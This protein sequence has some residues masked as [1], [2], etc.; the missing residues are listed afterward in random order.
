[1][2]VV[3]RQWVSVKRYRGT[4]AF[5]FLIPILLCLSPLVTG[6]VKEQWFYVVGG[7]AL[8]TMVLAPSALR[9]DFRRDLRRMLLLRSLPVKPLSMVLGQVGLPITITWIFQWFTICVAAIVTRPGGD[10]ILLWTALLNA[11]AVFIFAAENA[12]FLA[13]PHHERSEGVA[14]MVRAKLTFLA[15]GTLILL[16]LGLLVAWATLCRRLLSP[17]YAETAFVSGSLVASWAV[18][19]VAVA[20]ATICWRR[21]DAGID[22]PPQ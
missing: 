10:Q 20:A 14:M 9:L 6:Q 11:L 5:S 2:A 15:K 7:I 8:C 13:Y 21:F 17:A 22:I 12:L 1:M 19:L 16:A 4:I 3:S 18:A